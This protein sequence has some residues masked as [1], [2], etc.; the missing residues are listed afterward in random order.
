VD[1]RRQQRREQH[2]AEP[3]VLAGRVTQIDEEAGQVDERHAVCRADEMDRGGDREGEQKQ[4]CGGRDGV[5]HGVE[6]EVPL[7]A[8]AQAPAGEADRGEVSPTV[9]ER[10][11]PQE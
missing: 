7:H 8:A 4:D 2:V 5:H 9:Q 6:H 11:E 10:Q 1:Q 3:P